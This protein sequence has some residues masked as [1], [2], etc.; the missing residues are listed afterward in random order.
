MW[1]PILETRLLGDFEVALDA[2]PVTGLT[3]HLSGGVLRYL[4]TRP[5]FSAHRDEL[6]EVFWPGV[7][8]SRARNRLHVVVSAMRKA[9]REHTDVDAIVFSDGTYR[10]SPDLDVVVDAIEFQQLA[11]RVQIVSHSSGAEEARLA[12][13]HQAARL[14]RGHLCTDLPY[15]EWTIFLRERLRML[16]GDVLDTLLTAQ[17]QRRDLEGCISTAGRML[18]EDPCREDAHR[19]LIRSYVEV[20]RPAQAVRQ[21]ESCRRVMAAGLGTEPSASTVAAYERARRMVLTNG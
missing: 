21:Y 16:Y 8:P 3:G 13:A 18:E 15:E 5:R 12:A 1:R 6:M 17:W 10:I 4:L 20:G 14:Y 2:R 19:M 9:I 7:D 11:E